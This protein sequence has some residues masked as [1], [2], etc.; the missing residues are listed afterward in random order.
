MSSC[1][2]APSPRPRCLE[3]ADLRKEPHQFVRLRRTRRV[4]DPHRRRLTRRHPPAGGR[5]CSIGVQ[6]EAVSRII[7]RTPTPTTSATPAASGRA[8][9]GSSI[10]TST[11]RLRRHGTPPPPRSGPCPWP[12]C[13]LSPTPAGQ[14]RRRREPTPTTTFSPYSEALAFCTRP[15]TPWSLSFLH[16]PT[17]SSS[18]G[19]P[20]EFPWPY[21][22]FVRRRLHQLQDVK[23]HRDRLARSTT[24]RRLHPRSGNPRRPPVRP[25]AVS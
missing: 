19:R 6:P 20:R 9:A 25:C 14:E 17:A 13:S 16:E 5:P 2:R 23:G 11:T 24:T 3:D 21:E 7:A 12:K 18:P 10:S 1:R 22:L 15:D 4:R 8:P